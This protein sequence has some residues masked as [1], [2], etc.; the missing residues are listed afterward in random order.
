MLRYHE[1]RDVAEIGIEV[2]PQLLYASRDAT[3]YPAWERMAPARQDVWKFFE[4]S[5]LWAAGFVS[6]E[7]ADALVN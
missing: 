1:H 6:Y 3:N 5:G 2:E 7:A 4:Q